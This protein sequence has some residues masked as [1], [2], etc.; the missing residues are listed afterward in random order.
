MTI[1]QSNKIIS[2]QDVMRL[3]LEGSH[4]QGGYAYIRHWV[5]SIGIQFGIEQGQ[6]RWNSVWGRIPERMAFH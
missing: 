6:M 1:I 5:L 4:G 2:I 3:R